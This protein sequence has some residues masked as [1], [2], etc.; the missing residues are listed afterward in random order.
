MGVIALDIPIDFFKPLTSKY[1]QVYADC[2]L[3][4]FN[5]FK[6][7][8]SYGVNR[9]IVVKTLTDYFEVDDMEMTFDDE[10]TVIPVV[11]VSE[12][13][14]LIHEGIISGGMIPKIMNCVDAVN[15][16]V[17]RVHILDG[18]L[19]HCVLLEIFT[20][21]GIGTMVLKDEEVEK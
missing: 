21:Q 6:P 12:A 14:Q 11:N 9:E 13:P 8:I 1:R 18:R 15:G 7:E 10:E 19:P 5:T 4:I 17:N 16:G 3:L 20:N 2:I